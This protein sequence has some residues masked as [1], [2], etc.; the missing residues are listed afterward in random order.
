MIGRARTIQ[1]GTFS[2]ATLWDIGQSTG[3]PILQAFEGLWCYSD[4]EGRFEWKPRELRAVILPFWDGDFGQCLSA[5]AEASFVVPYEVLGR[6]YGLVRNFKKHQHINSRESES[7]LPPLPRGT[8][9]APV[10]DASGTG[11]RQEVHGL[12]SD[13]DQDNVSEDPESDSDSSPPSDLTGSAREGEKKSPFKSPDEREVF[14]H[15]ARKLWPL[16]HKHGA[17]RATGPRLSR[18]RARLREGRTVAELKRVVDAVTQSKFHLG[19]NDSGI[20][21]IEPKTIF[22]NTETVDKWLAKRETAATAKEHVDTERLDRVLAQAMRGEWGPVALERAQAGT[23]DVS[24]LCRAI[25]ANKVQRRQPTETAPQG[26][27]GAL[28]AQVGRKTA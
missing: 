21:Y 11:H 23:L 4:K 9:E 3:L 2:D 10:I 27:L 19:D 24:A 12:F 22:Q 18:I 5:L 16:V 13:L 25:D 15:W 20:S 8:R 7:R 28:V 1:P 17:A 6:K 26:R 14:E